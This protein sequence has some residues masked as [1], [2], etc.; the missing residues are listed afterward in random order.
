MNFK[1][2]ILSLFVLLFALSS[3]VL[4]ANNTRNVYSVYSDN[5]TG[6][7]FYGESVTV[8][9]SDEDGMKEYHWNQKMVVTPQSDGVV[10]GVQYSRYTI[11]AE[12]GWDVIAYT[13][14]T[15]S[16]TVA[17]RDMSAYANGSI[18][19]LAR[20]TKSSFLTAKVGY[21]YRYSGSDT[22]YTKTLS[23]LNFVADGQWH[24]LSIPVPSVNLGLVKALFLFQPMT[25]TEG[26]Y[27]DIDNIRWVKNNAGATFSVIRKKVSDNTVVSDQTAPISFS[28]DS[29]GQGWT[30]ADQYLELDIDGEMLNNNW[31]VRVFTNNDI[32]GLYN[33]N[34]TTDVLPT[35]WKASC[36]TLPYSYTDDKGANINTLQIG[37]NKNQAGDLLGL[38][39]AGKVAL[40]GEDVKW[41]YP[42]FFVTTQNDTSAASLVFCNQGC[43]TFE[44]TTS[45]GVTNQYYDP[46][47]NFYDRS[48]KLFFACNTKLAR[49][50]KYTASFVVKLSYE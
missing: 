12:M 25:L 36:T 33:V 20:S 48:P 2:F 9:S 29:Y 8:P 42:W 23:E 13:P 4:A 31:T 7:H 27:I 3:V 47:T 24:E 21:Q 17:P 39:D 19:F 44:N 40:I 6:A 38:Y 30:V 26:D 5:F 46:F 49:A 35:A 18:K 14:V 11:P 28:E 16:N 37:E 34:D 1:N 10:E 43:H 22:N 45:S 50:A 41:L 32:A 15:G